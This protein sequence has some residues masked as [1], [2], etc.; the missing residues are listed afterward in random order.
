VIDASKL[1]SILG[2]A[3]PVGKLGT[4]V[5]VDE[6]RGDGSG[7][8]N[9]SPAN[10][11]ES[12]TPANGSGKVMQDA[13]IHLMFWGEAWLSATNQPTAAAVATALTSLGSTGRISA[14]SPSTASNMPRSPTPTWSILAD[15]PPRRRISPTP[16]PPILSRL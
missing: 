5:R 8:D 14:N 12:T 1:P 15:R 9:Q 11:G 10:P 2:K 6:G 13:N 4:P 16:T 7:N 3:L